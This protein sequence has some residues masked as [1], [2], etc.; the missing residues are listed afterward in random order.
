V[1]I[2]FSI[3]A[4]KSLKGASFTSRKELANHIAKLIKAHNRT[5][6][7]FKWRKRDAVGSPLKNTYREFKQLN[8]IRYQFFN[9]YFLPYFRDPAARPSLAD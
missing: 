9:I 7:P 6:K 1:E 2:F 5:S 3:M 8:T 4:R